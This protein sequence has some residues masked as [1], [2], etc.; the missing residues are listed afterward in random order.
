MLPDK[1]LSVLQPWATL[2]LLGAKRL[3][4]RPWRTAHRGPLAIHAGRRLLPAG[5][6]LAAREP[7]RTILREASYASCDELPRG[8]VLG[9]VELVD[10]LAVEDLPPDALSESDLALGDFRPGR[11]VW[12]LCHP[13]RL[14]YPFPAVGRL[15]LFTLEK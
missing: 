2:I 5:R 3:E 6:A 12:Q 1:A 7:W 15:G 9:S 10:C 13:V 4:T 11:W 8:A 14:D